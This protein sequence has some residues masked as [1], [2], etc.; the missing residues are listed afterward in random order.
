V[1]EN[2][3]GNNQKEYITNPRTLGVN[4]SYNF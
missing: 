3:Y 2:Y 1:F 4:F